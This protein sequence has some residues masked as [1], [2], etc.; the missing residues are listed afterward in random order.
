[1]SMGRDYLLVACEYGRKDERF[2][3]TWSHW[4]VPWTQYPLVV[5]SSW[6]PGY[7]GGS[8]LNLLLLRHPEVDTFTITAPV[9]SPDNARLLER[10]DVKTGIASLNDYDKLKS[11]ASSS[12]VVFNIVQCSSCLWIDCTLISFVSTGKLGSSTRSKRNLGRNAAVL[13]EQ[14][15]SRLFVSYGKYE[16]A[17]LYMARCDSQ[18]SFPSV[19]RRGNRGTGR[20]RICDRDSLL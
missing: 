19:W 20:R 16:I 9:R 8:V 10:L 2:A 6:N 12:D 5:D 4:Y 18:T 14:R 3:P 13:R 15:S 11:L 1:M 7:V 17:G